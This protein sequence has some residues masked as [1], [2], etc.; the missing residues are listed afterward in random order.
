[1]DVYGRRGWPPP[2]LEIDLFRDRRAGNVRERR[3]RQRDRPAVAEGASV[4][5]SFASESSG[6]DDR[7]RQHH[8][9]E[10]A[11]ALHVLSPGSMAR[12]AADSQDHAVLLVPV[13]I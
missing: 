9:G 4:E 13:D 2:D 1:M 11:F 10:R 8:P 5:L 7:G 12:L 6:I 3:G